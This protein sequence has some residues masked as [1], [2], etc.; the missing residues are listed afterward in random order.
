MSTVNGTFTALNQA[1]SSILV[2]PSET[3]LITLSGTFVGLCMLQRMIGAGAAW[4]NAG[5]YASGVEAMSQPGTY[6]LICSRFTSGTISYSLYTPSATAVA[7]LTG[8]T[9][10]KASNTSKYRAARGKVLAGISNMVVLTSG[11]S[12]T[13]GAGATGGS[14][15]SA[16]LLG[17]NAISKSYPTQLAQLLTARGLTASSQSF[18]GGHGSNDWAAHDGRINM[19]GWLN[20]NGLGVIGSNTLRAPSAVADCTFTPTTAV[21]TVDVY[22]LRSGIGSITIKNDSSATL[23][24]IAAQTGSGMINKTTVVLDGAAGT[25]IIKAGYV[26][27]ATNLIGMRAYN[28]AV[29]EVSIINSAA[30]GARVDSLN[31]TWNANASAVTIAPDLTILA[32]TRNDY[33]QSTAIETYRSLYQL[34]ITAALTTG[35]CILVIEPMG[36]TVTGD[37]S[38]YYQ[39]VYD[40]AEVNDIPVVDF[41]RLWDVYANIS[42]WYID[43]I[44][45]VGFAYANVANEMAKVLLT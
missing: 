32:W 34:A 29:K 5:T 21:D 41:T 26:T 13:A 16:A 12:I 15:S 10:L 6:R 11:N 43:G 20:V 3:L 19:G 45:P 4:E 1:S 8:I 39:V 28:S 30:Y 37:P 25:K 38:P 36:A 7:S 31:D 33:G 14:G 22:V 40:L 42:T 23:A 35:D 44:H 17:S 24:T 27:A 18:V 9:N 2:R